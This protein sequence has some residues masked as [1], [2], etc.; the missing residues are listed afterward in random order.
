MYRIFVL[1]LPFIITGVMIGAYFALVAD[2][3]KEIDETNITQ[4]YIRAEH[5]IEKGDFEQAREFYSEIIQSDATEE[6]AWHEKGKLLNRFE[7][8]LEALDHYGEYVEL[9]PDSSRAAEGLDI[10]RYC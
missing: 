4:L 3:Q 6:K 10:A 2:V 7:M 1:I 9:F 8:C 5:F